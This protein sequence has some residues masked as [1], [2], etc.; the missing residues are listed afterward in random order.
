MRQKRPT[1]S[2]PAGAQRRRNLNRY[3]RKRHLHLKHRQREVER[4]RTLTTD[5]P[6]TTN[7]EGNPPESEH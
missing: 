4:M 1:T 2:R 3:L 5:T 7:C 6:D